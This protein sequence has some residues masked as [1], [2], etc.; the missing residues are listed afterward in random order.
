MI[1]PTWYY[2]DGKQTYGPIHRD[3]LIALIQSG[4]LRPEHCIL[5]QGTE[6]WQVVRSSPFAG[7]L[8]T[9]P[10]A[11]SALP[12]QP[13]RP[14]MAP[15]KHTAGQP[16]PK[17]APIS[18]PPAA[19]TS[20]TS[21]LMKAAVLLA[22]A[23]LGWWLTQPKT[24]P[25]RKT[26][27][28]IEGEAIKVL[29]VTGGE[30]EPQPMKQS[31]ALWSGD[32]HLWWHGGAAKYVLDLE[33]T[34]EPEQVG[35]Q[36]LKAAFTSSWDYGVVEV[37]VDGLKL[38]NPILDLQANGAVISGARDLGLIDLTAGPH[39]MSITLLGTNVINRDEKDAYGMGLDY[40]QLEPPVLDEAPAEV[41]TNIALKAQP[42]ASYCAQTDHVS[43]MNT[44]AEQ[45][46]RK[47]ED[48]SLP[49]HTWHPH[50]GS[51]EWTQYEWD[52]PQTLG[53]CRVFW[54]DDSTVRGGCALPAFWRLLY[55]EEATGAWVP[56][57]AA[58]PAATR[59]T[60]NSVK[61]PAVRTTALRIAV[62]CLEGYSAGICHWQALA[63]DTA[64]MPDAKTREPPDLFLG[65]LSP[66]HAQVGWGAYHS[67]LY[68]SI[69]TREGR[70][71]LHGGK[72]CSQHLWAHA[73][74]RIDFAIP[75]GYTRFTAYAIGPSDLATGAPTAGADSWKT[76]V[77]VDG[78]QLA[79]SNPLS[80]YKGHEFFVDITFPAGSKVLTL[81]TDNLGNGTFD[82]AF[83]A[84][85]TLLTAESQKLPSAATMTAHAPAHLF[86]PK[87][88]PEG[89]IHTS[90]FGTE[91]IESSRGG[92]RFGLR[93]INIRGLTYG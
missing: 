55:R 1:T 48:Q 22:V 78:R 74:S 92:E 77:L 29:K 38:K 59:D 21:W 12:Q 67:N 64:T 27:Q 57:Q 42:S 50:K 8:P 81:I 39:V 37:S 32:A 72:P 90:E 24:I 53:E 10:V 28:R 31:N 65:D 20:L 79:A 89:A 88:L 43:H 80:S 36:R 15:V 49:R 9:A 63:A 54:F 2:T 91:P 3:Q 11:S 93:F 25:T 18:Q 51:A 33:F 23:G 68:D 44:S 17:Q 5:P 7:Y 14:A 46:G 82:N 4:Q 40:I 26:V 60:W 85:P 19:Q 52:R 58:I 83:W 71:V 6:E 69:A 61:F 87:R 41:G 76:S 70:G 13:Q 35:R 84:F 16:P 34:V 30:V 86:S 73:N 47:S 66:L 75:E 62:Q 45:A 56:V